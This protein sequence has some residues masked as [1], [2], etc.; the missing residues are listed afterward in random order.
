MTDQ[1]S[2]EDLLVDEEE[3]NEELLVETVGEYVRIGRDSGELVPNPNYN[4]LTTAEKVVVSLLAQ[5]ARYELDMAE[6]EW[7]APSGISELS[8]VKVGT[9]Y[10]KVRQLV[11]EGVLQD[12]DG[13]YRIPSV[14]V[15]RAKEF[16]RDE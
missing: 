5:K 15:E 12:D 10:P 2:L 8:G 1:S 16:L 3:L 4:D 11:E 14:N 7:L 6:E 13:V 9:V